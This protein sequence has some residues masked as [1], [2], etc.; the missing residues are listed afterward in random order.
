MTTASQQICF[1]NTQELKERMR[2]LIDHLRA[3]MGYV[4]DPRTRAM[5]ENSAAVLTGLIKEFD[6]YE[7]NHG[8][9]WKTGIPSFEDSEL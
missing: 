6:E 4:A 7:M 3:D 2:E 8:E 9:S 1:H 5:F